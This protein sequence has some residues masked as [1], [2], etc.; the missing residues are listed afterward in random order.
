MSVNNLHGHQLSHTQQQTACPN[1]VPILSCLKVTGAIHSIKLQKTPWIYNMH[2]PCAEK[3]R[4]PDS[5]LL[6]SVS[7][8]ESLTYNCF[9]GK[10]VIQCLFT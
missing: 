9:L 1:E 5:F 3:I 7:S 8:N 4:T 10:V 2:I 6:F